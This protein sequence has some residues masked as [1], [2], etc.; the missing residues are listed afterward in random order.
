MLAVNMVRWTRGAENAI[1]NGR[2]DDVDDGLYT[3]ANIGEYAD[4]LENQLKST[5]QLVR[6]DLSPLAR[7]TLG[8]LVVLDV[9]AK[10]V[11]CDLRKAG[12]TSSQD[13]NWI[14]QL[15]YVWEEKSHGK[16][17]LKVQMISASLS[18]E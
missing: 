12:C 6:Q 5:V 13:F 10:D 3:Y 16:Q 11:I 9:H 4:Y 18:Y 2:G 7:L 17:D 8:S 15:R 1:M 14:S